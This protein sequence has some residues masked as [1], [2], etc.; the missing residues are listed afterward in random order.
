MKKPEKLKSI[1]V[2]E[3]LERCTKLTELQRITYT[4]ALSR[5]IQVAGEE[6]GVQGQNAAVSTMKCVLI[7]L[8]EIHSND[9]CSY[10]SNAK[11]DFSTVIVDKIGEVLGGTYQQHTLKLVVMTDQGKK[12]VDL[13]FRE[14]VK[15]IFKDDEVSVTNVV[16]RLRN[17]F[18]GG[19]QLDLLA[20][21]QE[22]V[23]LV[24]E[25]KGGAG[26]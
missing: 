23:A 22:E 16:K 26:E 19:S 18:T 10:A 3:V 17:R 2:L 12:Q 9:K 25:H 6:G 13:P 8:E 5:I 1:V 11:L 4:E 14:H 7:I 20:M 21:I 24:A 15:H